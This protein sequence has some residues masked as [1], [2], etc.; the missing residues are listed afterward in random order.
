MAFVALDPE[1]FRAAPWPPYSMS[2]KALRARLTTLMG[3]ICTTTQG[4]IS[5]RLRER[6]RP[7]RARRE[8]GFANAMAPS[9]HNKRS[10]RGRANLKERVED[11]RR[12]AM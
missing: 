5:E 11:D 3:R 10:G 2:C 8:V 9:P 7:D 12:N 4:V 6:P 1:H